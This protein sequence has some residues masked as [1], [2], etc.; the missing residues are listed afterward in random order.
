[1]AYN[2]FAIDKYLNAAEVTRQLD[3]LIK[4]P[5]YSV[6]PDKL[7]MYEEEY[8]EK[9]C[10]KSKAMI[11]EAKKV[12]PGGVQHNLA[13]NYPFPIV[14]EKAEGARLYDI[15]G[16]WYYFDD[17]GVMQTG[18][19]TINGVLYYLDVNSGQ[20]AANAVL[21][22][23][24]TAYQA[25]ASGACTPAAVAAEGEET[26]AAGQEGTQTSGQDTAAAGPSTAIQVEM[27]PGWN[28]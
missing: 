3:E 21:D 5:V 7:K 17:D 8:F 22:Y 10:S 13:F 2:G 14:I 20:M 19:Q 28:L 24:G 27:G 15:D 6:R 23:N 12:I 18:W 25:D 26:Q 4:K 16:N 9:K 1:M 11:T